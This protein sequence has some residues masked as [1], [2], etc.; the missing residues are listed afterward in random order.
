L[1]WLKIPFIVVVLLILAVALA[2]KPILG[3]IDNNYQENNP[4][5]LFDDNAD[6]WTAQGIG[7]G[8]VMMASASASTNAK[9][10]ASSLQIIG[11][12]G[13][14]SY[15]EIGHYFP[16]TQN[17]ASYERVCFWF[18]GTNSSQN[19]ELAF[20]APDSSNQLMAFFNDNF[21][22]WGHMIIPF[23]SFIR[24]NS[25]S[26]S[27]IREV[28]FFFSN[29]PFTFYFDRFVLDTSSSA[30]P[31]PTQINQNTPA[32]TTPGTNTPSGPTSSSQ[33][34]VPNNSGSSSPTEILPAI[35]FLS[36]SITDL[37][38]GSFPTWLTWASVLVV[39]VIV[40]ISFAY[41]ILSRNSDED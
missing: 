36:P 26:I 4:L 38:S 30:T 24:V 16:T 41:F 31:I 37:F 22:G 5:V 21:T 10:G 32:S 3:A 33:T 2:P 39:A 25:P 27:S 7:S 17:W 28:G 6:F 18:Y 9:T 11:A 35:S 23:D 20:A 13:S 40:V 15:V 12:A 8:R 14:Y 29:A 19:I 1:K 34:I